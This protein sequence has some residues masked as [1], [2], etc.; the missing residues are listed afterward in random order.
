MRLPSV[1]QKRPVQ[2]S[3]ILGAQCPFTGRSEEC[4]RM[5]E[6]RVHSRAPDLGVSESD[7][8]VHEFPGLHLC[9][10]SGTA[11]QHPATLLPT[12]FFDGA[13]AH[14][15]CS[16]SA[17]LLLHYFDYPILSSDS[18]FSS[19]TVVLRKYWTY[20]LHPHGTADGP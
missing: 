7:T 13:S 6:S 17:G 10:C 5:S 11:G 1:R 18:P 9:F 20:L 15:P 3:Q 16:S 8:V 14:C 19:L 2:L 4:Q 12:P